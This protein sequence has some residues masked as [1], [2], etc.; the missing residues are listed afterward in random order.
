MDWKKEICC[1]LNA[2][3]SRMEKEGGFTR[4]GEGHN[5]KQYF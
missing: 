2:F 3:G 1:V 5:F 4:F